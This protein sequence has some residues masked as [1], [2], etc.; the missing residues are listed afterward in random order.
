MMK[1]DHLVRRSKF[2]ATFPVNK[3]HRTTWP[4]EAISTAIS[5]P[6]KNSDIYLFIILLLLLLFL[7]A[8]SVSGHEING[9]PRGCVRDSGTFVHLWR[10]QLRISNANV[11]PTPT[12]PPTHPCR[13]QQLRR[14][15]LSR[16]FFLLFSDLDRWLPHRN[17]IKD[18][19]PALTIVALVFGMCRYASAVSFKWILSHP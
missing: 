6:Q 1:L 13:P 8:S 12:V 14:I 3:T 18:G 16:C 19:L 11:Y 15:H 2:G 10:R 9:V 17:P 4:T 5:F 7:M